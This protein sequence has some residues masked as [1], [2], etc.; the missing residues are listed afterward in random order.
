MDKNEKPTICVLCG[1]LWGVKNIFTNRCENEDCN[2]F[3]TWG[4]ELMKPESFTIDESGRWIPNPPPNEE[5]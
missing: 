3:C 5:F 2:G 1:T 4:K